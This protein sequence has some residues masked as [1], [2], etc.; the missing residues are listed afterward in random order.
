MFCLGYISFANEILRHSDLIELAQQSARNNEK[1]GIT[2]VLLY[3]N[4]L[5][6][7]FLEGEE[8]AVRDLLNRIERDRRHSRLTVVVESPVPTRHFPGWHM[9]LADAE[10]F[11]QESR[12][13][14]RHLSENLPPLPET[15]ISPTIARLL[16][17][18]QRFGKF[19]YPYPAT[20][21]P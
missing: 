11:P 9:A 6:L 14:I 20:S 17:T 8:Q 21:P 1:L 4:G 7:Q 12:D 18:F 10:K 16:S 5:F 13:I 3:D 2:G 19:G 15:I